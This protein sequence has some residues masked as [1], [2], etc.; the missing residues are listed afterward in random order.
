MGLVRSPRTVGGLQ[1]SANPLIQFRRVTLHPSPD[2]RWIYGEVR[3]AHYL[4]QIA[5]AEGV[6]QV[7]ANTKHD[8]LIRKNVALGTVLLAWKPSSFTLTDHPRPFAIQP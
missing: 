1:L 4:R 3:L 6:A 5:I 2:R 8:D 7:P